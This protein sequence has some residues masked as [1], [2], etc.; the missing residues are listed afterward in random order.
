MK[1]VTTTMFFVL[2]NLFGQI[3]F[4]QIQN[5]SSNTVLVELINQ[6]WNGA[7]WENLDRT[8]TEFNSLIQ[9]KKITMFGW[10]E[11]EWKESRRTTLL[12]DSVNQLIEQYTEDIFLN[13]DKTS[14]YNYTYDEKGRI[15]ERIEK[16]W[17]QDQ[18]KYLI[19]KKI[20]HYDD[21]NNASTETYQS[22]KDNTWLNGSK[23]YY[24]YDNKY[25]LLQRITQKWIDSSWINTES[26]N[27]IYNEYNNKIKSVQLLWLDTFWD[28][29]NMHSFL[30][31]ENNY[32]KEEFRR[33][34]QNG[35]WINDTKETF[36]NTKDGNVIHRMFQFWDDSVLFNGTQVFYYYNEKEKV[37][38][39]VEQ[40]W[41]NDTWANNSKVGYEYDVND[42][43]IIR[44]YHLWKDSIWTYTGRNLYAYDNITA[45]EDNDNRPNQFYLSNNYPNPF[46]PITTIQYSVPTKSQVKLTV[47]N[48]LGSKVTTLVNDVKEHGNYQIIF[49]ASTL[50]SGI[51][52]YR[53]EIG[54]KFSATKKMLFLK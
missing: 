36:I 50:S 20:M 38:K 32:L 45:V 41:D 13:W 7:N 21:V 37:T 52:F 39:Q 42:N 31:D 29:L 5:Q 2:L 14:A 46:N 48:L 24:T 17:S 47:Y 40:N 53:I 30:Y 16:W 49:D 22:F 4:S 51:Y 25:N 33:I 34:R 15:S 6:W 12:Y 27:Y 26:Y 23:I 3:I 28:T 9:K 11:P 44:T 43:L 18:G 1:R 54:I 19:S 10:N 35:L 8:V